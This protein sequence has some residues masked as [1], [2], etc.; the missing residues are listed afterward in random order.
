MFYIER[1]IPICPAVVS[2]FP[3]PEFESG[4]NIPS[5]SVPAPP[6]AGV[7]VFDLSLLLLALTLAAFIA[8]KWRSRRLMALLS[9]CSLAYF[10]FVRHGCLCSVGAL[11]NVSLALCDSAAPMPWYVFAYFAAPLVFALF[12][13]R[14][15]CGGV[16]PLGMI[17]DVVAAK[18]L[19]VPSWIER[20][21]G[22]APYL[23]LGLAVLFAATGTA[24]II[25]RFDPFVG[26]F[27]FSGPPWMILAGALVLL[28][29]IFVARPYCRYICPY[30]VLL[31]W[32]SSVSW[33]HL[34]IAPSHEDGK[35]GGGCVVCALCADSCSFGAIRKPVSAR[36]EEGRKRGIRKL[37][38]TL[39]LAPLIVVV[40]GFAGYL[41]SGPLAGCD[42]R[43]AREM[44]LSHMALDSHADTAIS[45]EIQAEAEW[46]RWKFRVGA[47][48]VG[49]FFGLAVAGTLVSLS[50]KPKGDIFEPDKMKCLSC[51]RCVDY[52]P[53]HK[54]SS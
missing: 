6:G 37:A 47:T 30:G 46:V 2:R 45:A 35:D 23:Y 5:T 27:R 4:H 31:R 1:L 40:F 9:V 10:G 19:R 20:V 38:R 48:A 8:L 12:F 26:F 42:R 39:L 7:H 28:A 43:V 54:R 22:L 52:C 21:L 14:V 49:V 17:Q 25:C 36:W 11:Q 33:R 3:R 41:A 51:V 15:F 53:I 18:P 32:A 44:V 29:G 50:V 13:G 34:T 24:F 16:C